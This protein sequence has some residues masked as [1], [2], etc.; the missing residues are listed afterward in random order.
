MQEPV[1]QKAAIEIALWVPFQAQ[2]TAGPF[3]STQPVIKCLFIEK[4]IIVGKANERF[5]SWQTFLRADWILVF[6]PGSMEFKLQRLLGI[7]TFTTRKSVCRYLGPQTTGWRVWR[8]G[9]SQQEAI[10]AVPLGAAVHVPQCL[11]DRRFTQ[12]SWTEPQHGKHC[13]QNE[14]KG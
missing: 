13:L 3:Y 14:G 1:T 2:G 4:S 12:V 8:G 11:E 5:V 7:S 6:T 9:G 10:L